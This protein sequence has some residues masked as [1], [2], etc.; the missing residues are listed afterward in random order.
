MCLLLSGLVAGLL[1]I[2][3]D[4][5]LE[6]YALSIR[7]GEGDWSVIALGWE[8]LPELW[9]LF[10]MVAVV[11]SGLTLFITKRLSSKKT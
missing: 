2:Y 7:A 4:Y 9:P 6:E 11:A 5:L 10:V 1:L 3:S 8:I